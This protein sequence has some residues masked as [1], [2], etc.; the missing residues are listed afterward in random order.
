[1]V[2]APV[3]ASSAGDPVAAARI[4][5]T[6]C[7]TTEV[8]TCAV[9]WTL[10]S[11]GAE[12]NVVEVEKYGGL[13]GYLGCS[14]GSFP[15]MVFCGLRCGFVFVIQRMFFVL[16]HWIGQ[17]RVAGAHHAVVDWSFDPRSCR[18]GGEDCVGL[19]GTG[20]GLH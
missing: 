11:W 6:L 16:Q 4:T 7:R 17:L 19:A 14:D 8:L 9:R 10:H 20:G 13:P 1:M 12:S 3:R 18:T 2:S 15:V 5:D